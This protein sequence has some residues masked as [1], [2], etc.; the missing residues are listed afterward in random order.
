MLKNKQ[1]IEKIFFTIGEVADMIGVSP[2]TIRYWESNFNELVPKKSTGGTRMFSRD[3]IEL[4][5]LINHLVKERGLT[6]RGARLK[7]KHSRIDTENTW[8]VVSRLKEIRETLVDIKNEL[9]EE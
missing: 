2:S 9:G 1:N 8:E 4:L 5:K 6:V 7:L 3:N